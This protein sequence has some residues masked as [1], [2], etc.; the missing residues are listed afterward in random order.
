MINN[1]DV[2]IVNV[3][4][5]SIADFKKLRLEDAV[6]NNFK[7]YLKNSQIF[8]FTGLGMMFRKSIISWTGL[9]PS[10]TICIDTEFSFRLTYLGVKI[11]WT[12]AAISIRIGNPQSNLNTIA[13][14]KI[15]VEI[16]RFQYFYNSNY[17]AR[18]NNIFI[19]N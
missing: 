7:N 11:A 9:F 2:I 10:N 19:I 6:E 17:R 3:Y 14:E 18:N 1:I 16:D 12:D 5:T 15:A 8:C 4:D 13:K